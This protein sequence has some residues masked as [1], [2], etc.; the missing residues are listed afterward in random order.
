MKRLT[1]EKASGGLRSAW[2]AAARPTST[3]PEGR[4]AT[5]EGVVRPPS[6]LGTTTAR[7]ASSTAT[8]LLVVPRSMPHTP[9]RA[10][11]HRLRRRCRQGGAGGA[12]VRIYK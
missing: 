2:A 6:A 11:A 10:A 5:T 1:E 12:D 7:P 4:Y 8:Q 9:L 3:S